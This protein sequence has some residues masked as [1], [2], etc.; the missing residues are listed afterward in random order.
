MAKAL[1]AFFLVMLS[2]TAQAHQITSGSGFYAG[3]SHPVLGLD[4][5]LAMLSVGILSAQ[6]GDRAIW[7]VPATFV[8]VMT[9]GGIL[10]ISQ[11]GI[12]FVE[13][14]IA[15]SVVLLGAALTAGR[16]SPMYAGM[17]FVGVFAVF[18]GYAHGVEMPGLANPLLYAAGFVSAT[19]LIH[20][21]GVLFGLI[22]LKLDNNDHMLR[23]CGAGIASCGLYFLFGA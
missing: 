1:L 2:S 7:T 13:L 18:H 3:F 14:G 11:I 20:L 6:M 10:G 5:L 16:K 23:V 9:L 17:A 19:A 8:V 21:M 22:T 12:P 15:L 4:H